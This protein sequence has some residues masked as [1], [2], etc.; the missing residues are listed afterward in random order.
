[1]T[2]LVIL[3]GVM[4]LAVVVTATVAYVMTQQ[5]ADARM[6]ALELKVLLAHTEPALH[7]ADKLANHTIEAAGQRSSDSF[8]GTVPHRQV[9]VARNDFLEKTSKLAREYRVAKG[10]MKAEMVLDP[11]DIRDLGPTV[12][13]APSEIRDGAWRRL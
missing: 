1:M 13:G 9:E 8:T 5:L 3:V 11:D 12:S 10:E 2:L 4:F 7:A 6:D